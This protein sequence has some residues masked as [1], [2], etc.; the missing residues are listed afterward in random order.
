[1]MMIRSRT[2]LKFAK[3]QNCQMNLP[4]ICN[5]DPKT[6]V[7][8]HSG[9]LHDGKGTGLKSHD[10]FVC[11]MCSECHDAFDGRNNS[12]GISKSEMFEYFHIGM[13]RTMVLLWENYILTIEGEKR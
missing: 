10:L 3:G 4:G 2:L 5:S 8:A 7:A 12:H 1:M 13:K 9:Y 6:T 11:Y